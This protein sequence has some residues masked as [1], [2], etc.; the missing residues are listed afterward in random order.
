[1]YPLREGVPMGTGTT[2]HP[3][4]IWVWNFGFIQSLRRELGDDL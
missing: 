1:M 2:H 3:F 4:L